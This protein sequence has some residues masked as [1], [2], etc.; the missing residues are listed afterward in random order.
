MVCVLMSCAMAVA[1]RCK[2]DTD[3]GVAI[4]PGR[5]EPTLKVGKGV[6]DG[7]KKNFFADMST[8]G[9]QG[10]TSCPKKSPKK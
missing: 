10:S 3:D 2:V 7:V 1:D 5:E 4:E 8:R 6:A 9:R